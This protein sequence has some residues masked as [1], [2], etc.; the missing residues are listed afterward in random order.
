MDLKFPIVAK[1]TVNIRKRF[2]LN[3]KSPKDYKK[4]AWSI[5]FIKQLIHTSILLQIC[6]G[7]NQNN[8][9]SKEAGKEEKN[10]E[11]H[12]KKYF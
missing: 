9:K 7:E 6:G 8:N 12:W 1:T 5:N 10:G 2:F 11:C 3:E 4:K